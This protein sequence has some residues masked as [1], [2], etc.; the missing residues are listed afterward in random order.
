M[1]RPRARAVVSLAVRVGPART[2][3]LTI[4]LP[5]PLGDRALMDVT[6]L[7]YRPIVAP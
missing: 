6:L 2:P 7:P 5:G 4:D 3:G 1:S